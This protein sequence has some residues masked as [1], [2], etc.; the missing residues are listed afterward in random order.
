MVMETTNELEEFGEVEFRDV[1]NNAPR[2]MSVSA[3]GDLQSKAAHDALV[4]ASQDL[5]GLADYIEQSYSPDQDL[6]GAQMTNSG[7]EVNEE[8]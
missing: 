1:D 2:V 3:Y 5:L 4:N 7:E 6:Q 8:R